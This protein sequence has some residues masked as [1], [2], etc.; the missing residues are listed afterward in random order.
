[1][2]TGGVLALEE[3]I[4]GQYNQSLLSHQAGIDFKTPINSSAW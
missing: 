2:K 4:H 3:E 1:M